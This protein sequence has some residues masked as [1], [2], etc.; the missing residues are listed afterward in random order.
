MAVIAAFVLI[1]LAIFVRGRF[2]D[3]GGGGSDGPG[4]QDGGLP[5]VACTPDLIELCDALA[6]DGQ[7]ARDP[8]TLDLADASAPDA[9]VDAWITWSPAPQ[10]ANFEVQ[11]DKVWQEPEVLG[12]AA[13][14][15]LIDAASAAGLPSACRSNPTWACLGQAAPALSVG[16][17]DPATAEG[18]ARL[19][20][21][22]RTFTTDDDYTLLDTDALDDLIASPPDG[23]S[24]AEE[25]ADR[26]TTRPGS[27]S[28]TSGPDDLLQ[29]Q[30]RT[31]QGE[32]RGLR[33]LT[34]TPRARLVVV[35]TERVGRSGTTDGI[36]CDPDPSEA[37]EGALTALGIE[38]CTGTADPALAGFLFQVQKKV[39]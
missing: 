3:D 14:S 16:V 39:G 11:P 17:G 13:S 8:V 34:P 2:A 21:F 12:S 29:A 24:D 4:K 20:P 30:T 25:M 22:A 5:V 32:Q 18:I 27:L 37:L 23:Q 26:L 36:G 19:A 38:P 9:D 7:I 15:V 10:L 1:A 33:V 6:D 28:M 35:L 31:P